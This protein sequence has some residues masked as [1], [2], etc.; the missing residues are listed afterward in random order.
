ALEMVDRM[1]QVTIVAINGFAVGGGLHLALACD[2]RIAA[3]TATFWYPEITLGS[4]VGTWQMSRLMRIVGPAKVREMILTGDHYTAPQ[5]L[6]MGLV[7]KVVPRDSL[8]TEANALVS[9]LLEKKAG[10]LVQAKAT[11]NALASTS[12]SDGFAVSPHLFLR[13]SQSFQNACSPFDKLRVSGG[14]SVHGEPACPEQSRRVE[15]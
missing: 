9:R 15:P 10:I 8:L 14:F 13:S 4:V 3:D 7:T 5:M 12:V 11:I 1:E 2:F 6:D